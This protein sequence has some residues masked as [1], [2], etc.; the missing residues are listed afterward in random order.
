MS[1]EW[2]QVPSARADLEH[3]LVEL[4]ALALAPPAGDAAYLCD[5]CEALI[6]LLDAG[7]RCAVTPEDDVRIH[8]LRTQI[9]HQ[10]E[11]T[12]HVDRQ[13]IESVEALEASVVAS[14][15]AEPRHRL[16]IY[17]TL[18]PGEVNHS[19]IAGIPGQWSEGFVRGELA[20]TGW[21][22]EHGFPALTWRPDGPRVDVQL[23]T[24][25]ELDRHW[26]RLDDFEGEGYCRILV[27]VEDEPGRIV[28]VAYLYADRP[29]G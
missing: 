2:W 4:N 29:A 15:L 26:Q 21:G 12:V 25:P 6:E 19:Q 7:A 10:L 8:A 11:A 22:A 24:S 5:L 13:S 16:A 9:D 14:L 20:Y 3:A 17:G 23:F 27:P 28:A 18:A 1:L